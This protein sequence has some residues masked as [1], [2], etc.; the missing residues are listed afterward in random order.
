MILYHGAWEEDIP[1]I[2]KYG[3]TPKREPIPGLPGKF[4]RAAVYLTPEPKEAAFFGDTLIKLNIPKT[5]CHKAYSEQDVEE[6]GMLK[7]GYEVHEYVVYRHIPPKY[8]IKTS[9]APGW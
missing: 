3:L 2:L 4:R 1:V 5:W 8:I 7:G 9:L 6:E